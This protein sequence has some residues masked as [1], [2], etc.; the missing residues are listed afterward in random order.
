MLERY[1]ECSKQKCKW[2]GTE[3]EKTGIPDKK[4]SFVE[5]QVCPIC[6]N[7]SF[8][9]VKSQKKIDKHLSNPTVGIA[10]NVHEVLRRHITDQAKKR[11]L[12]ESE[13]L[14]ECIQ[15]HQEHAGT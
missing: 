4:H 2:I 3:E 10:Y 5:H 11:Q 15:Y 6:G 9:E 13:I 14:S 1:W 8:Y 7:D 12:P